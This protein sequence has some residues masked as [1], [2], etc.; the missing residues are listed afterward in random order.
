MKQRDPRRG[1]FKPVEDAIVVGQEMEEGRVG[2]GILKVMDGSKLDGRNATTTT[3]TTTPV[4]VRGISELS[5][6]T[7][8][9][10]G[11]VSGG[12]KEEVVAA[13]DDGKKRRKDKRRKKGWC[14]K[15]KRPADDKAEDSKGKTVLLRERFDIVME[16]INDFLTDDEEACDYYKGI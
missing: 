1:F 7:T 12:I 4:G 9:E 2:R 13:S 6:V 15:R 11:V 16:G 5:H 8:K 3:T 10:N 14:K